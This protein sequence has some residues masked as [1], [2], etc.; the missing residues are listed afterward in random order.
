M[1]EQE[2]RRPYGVSVDLFVTPNHLHGFSDRRVYDDNAHIL[3][4]F[5]QGAKGMLWCSQVAPGHE[6]GLRLR[7]YGEKASLQ[8]AQEH[9]NEM[10]MTPLGE[11][12]RR[13][14]RAGGGFRPGTLVHAR[15]PAGHPEGD[16]EGFGTLYSD[17]AEVLNSPGLTHPAFL[18]GVADGVH[19]M[20][21]IDAALRSAA[22]GGSWTGI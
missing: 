13:I 11:A 3:L 7:V 16:L 2:T 17:I 5:E 19:G 18:P 21:F 8:W 9:P 12:Q 1:A 6:N 4:R 15:L 14:T 20:E 22:A 10:I